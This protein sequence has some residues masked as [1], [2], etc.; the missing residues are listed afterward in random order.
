MES[1]FPESGKAV[2]S[3]CLSM[4]AERMQELRIHRKAGCLLI[5]VMLQNAFCL[6]EGIYNPVI[7][8]AKL[9]LISLQLVPAPGVFPFSNS[10]VKRKGG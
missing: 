2:R 8:T 9:I 7:H 3:S 10:D 4:A 6:C 5:V 1:R